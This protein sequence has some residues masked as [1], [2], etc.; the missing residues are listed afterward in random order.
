[1]TS[2]S[3]HELVLAGE[4]PDAGREQ[5]RELVAGVLRKSGAVPEDLDGPVESL[6]ATTTYDGVVLQPLYTAA[7]TAPAAGYPGLPPYVRGGTAQGAVATGW[8]VRQRHTDPDPET[9]RKA[10]LADLEN[11]V[12]SLWLAGIPVD[13][14]AHVLQDVYLDLAPVTLDAGADFRA[15]GEELLRIHADKGIPAGEVKGNLGADPIGLHARTAGGADLDG[16]AALALRA[17]EYPAL[18]S[19]VV[20]GLPY[21]QAGGSD[22]EELGASIA[23]G[24]AYLRALTAAGLTVEAAA[25]Q[26]EFRYAATADQ[27]LTIAKFRAA[28]RLWARVAEVSG[29]A[30][31]QRQ[32]AVTSPAMMT[33]R[34]PWVNMLRTTLACFGAGVGGADAVTVLPFDAA[35]GLP[36]G[37]ARRVARNTQSVLLEESKLAGVIDPAGGSWFVERLTDD[38]ARSAWDWFTEIERAGG[39][40]AALDTGV[41]SD[42]LAATW[43]ARSANL[44]TRTDA[45]TGVSEFPNLAEKPITR[46]PEPAAPTGGLPAVRYAEAYEELRDRS[47]RVLAETGS[48]PRIFLATLGPVAAHTGRATFAANLFQAGGIETVAGPP[49][50]FAASG[51]AVAC[52]CGS[53]KSYAADGPAAVEQ[54]GQAAKVL[55]AGRAELS[56]VDGNVFVGC[57]ALAVLS[58]IMETLGVTA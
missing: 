29:F 23:G 10:V 28:R 40:V 48:R 55:L 20:D 46:E 49:E 18:R 38:L 58:D 16:A 37:F 26:L 22:A 12:T 57:D 15:A 19:I 31:P 8:D 45:L 17:A 35:L 14:L 42:R 1:M 44:A 41:I 13:A 51:A 11:G 53:D 43:E 27:F 9:S 32:H 30:A 50:E 54:L 7:D 5:W 36:D 24:V 6:L 47:D 4:F 39:V 3:A 2:P 33:R 21:H 34:D 56:G 52:L 25:A